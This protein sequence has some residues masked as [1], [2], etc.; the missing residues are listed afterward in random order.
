MKQYTLLDAINDI[1]TAWQ[2]IAPDVDFMK[3]NQST[4]LVYFEDYNLISLY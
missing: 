1:D 4:V 2:S 3:N